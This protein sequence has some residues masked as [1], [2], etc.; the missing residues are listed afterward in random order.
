MRKL[1]PPPQKASGSSPLSEGEGNERPTEAT[2]HIAMKGGRGYYTTAAP[3]PVTVNNKGIKLHYS[4]RRDLM[5]QVSILPKE[6]ISK[7]VL[8]YRPKE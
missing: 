7:T 8:Y 3:Q 2:F 1:I 6:L 4:S 5:A